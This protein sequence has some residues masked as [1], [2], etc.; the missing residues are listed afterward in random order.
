[1]MAASSHDD[2]IFMD[3]IGMETP[4]SSDSGK[5][6]KMDEASDLAASK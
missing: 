4:S 2:Q 5:K 1:M 6:R 3:A